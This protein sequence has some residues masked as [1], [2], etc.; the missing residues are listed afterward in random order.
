MKRFRLSTLMLL[1]VIAA[2]GVALVVQ[3]RRA[4]RREAELEARLAESWPELR[5]LVEEL[6]AMN[7][8]EQS[9]K[10]IDGK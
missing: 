7:R 3:H 8:S 2:L 1:V 9:A 5:V 6:K 10:G 4:A